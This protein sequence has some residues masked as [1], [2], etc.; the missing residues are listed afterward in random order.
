[1]QTM[2]VGNDALCTTK[3]NSLKRAGRAMRQ[4]WPQNR[5]DDKVLEEMKFR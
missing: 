4:I 3:R 5:L 2:D 1:M